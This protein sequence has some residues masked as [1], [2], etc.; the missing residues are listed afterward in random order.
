M[1]MKFFNSIFYKKIEFPVWDIF[2]NDFGCFQLLKIEY[3]I[4]NRFTG[5]IIE[6]SYANN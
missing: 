2:E 5:K 6:R 3:F 1:M 4:I